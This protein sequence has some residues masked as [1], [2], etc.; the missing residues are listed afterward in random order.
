MGKGAIGG[1]GRKVLSNKHT[2]DVN[3]ERPALEHSGGNSGKRGQVPGLTSHSTDS[4]FQVVNK[5]QISFGS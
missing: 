4:G 5:I 2:G 3:G 1:Q